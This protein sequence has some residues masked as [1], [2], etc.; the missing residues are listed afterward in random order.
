MPIAFQLTE[1]VIGF[2]A[3]AA[4]GG[5]SV[6]VVYRELIAPSEATLLLGRLERMQRALFD[7]IPGFILSVNN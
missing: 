2:A 4:S 5:Q 3:T 6:Q 7:L 1:R